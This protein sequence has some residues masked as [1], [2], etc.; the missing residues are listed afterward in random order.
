MPLWKD[1]AKFYPPQ[2]NMLYSIIVLQ[3]NNSATNTIKTISSYCFSNTSQF[4]IINNFLFGQR[5]CF[6]QLT[7]PLKVDAGTDFKYYIIM[8]G[9]H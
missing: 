2:L 7:T 1:F 4:I 3:E 5:A 9:C 6:F 8:L